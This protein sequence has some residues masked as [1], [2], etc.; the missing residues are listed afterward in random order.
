MKINV[1]FILQ[2]V[3]FWFFY[4]LLRRYFLWPFVSYIKKKELTKEKFLADLA[5]HELQIK[6]LIHTKQVL[7]AQFKKNIK[8]K[9][10]TQQELSYVEHE[11]IRITPLL[12]HEVKSVE[13]S[14]KKLIAQSVRLSH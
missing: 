7:L 6:E 12:D 11:E 10:F 1:T 5:H 13:Q 9:Y 14:A 2:I 4:C 3:N 8:V